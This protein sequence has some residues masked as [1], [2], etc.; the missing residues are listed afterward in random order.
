MRSLLFIG[1]SRE[2]LRAFPDAAREQA[3]RQLWFVQLGGDPADW[4]PMSGVGP[5]A[6]EI[7][8]RDASGAYRII[9]VARFEEA[10]YVLHCFEKKTEKTRPADIRLAAARYRE[11]AAR[12]RR[13][14]H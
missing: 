11:A 4:K 12:S 6:R 5:G 1:R 9:Y 13:S 8:V 2:D 3:G 10:V 7:R 14:P